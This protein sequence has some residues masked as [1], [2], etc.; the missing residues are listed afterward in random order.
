[1]TDLLA[2]MQRR[3]KSLEGVLQDSQRDHEEALNQQTKIIHHHQGEIET[4]KK[5]ILDRE[6][7]GIK[8]YDEIQATKR[9]TEDR[10]SEIYTHNRDIDQVRKANEQARREIEFLQ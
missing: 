4:L 9:D 3:I 8:V 5:N 10:E 1:M 2:D 7:E 6:Q